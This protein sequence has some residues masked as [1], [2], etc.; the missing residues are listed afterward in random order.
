MKIYL[1]LDNQI[2][3]F[4][5]PN[6]IIGSYTFDYESEEEHKLIN[7]EARDGRWVIYSTVDVTLLSDGALIGFLPLESGK[8]Y[9]LRRRDKEYLIYY[10]D[11]SL[12][13]VVT[14]S[15]NT[16]INVVLGNSNSANI[17]YQCELLNNM[18][19]KIYCEN[20]VY[21]LENTNN[22]RGIYI[23]NIALKSQKYAI[24]MRK[25]LIL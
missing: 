15:Y 14:Y 3:T 5:L 9:T 25:F 17:M 1:Y 24:N 18:S 11:L 12:G 19:L 7:V 8:F 4:S 23:N 13:S 21:L 22:S 16:D 2:F 6:E 20:S 10:A